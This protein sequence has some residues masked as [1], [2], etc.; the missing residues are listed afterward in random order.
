MRLFLTIDAQ[1]LNLDSPSFKKLKVGLK[2]KTIDHRWVP[3]EH[4]HIPV[5]SLGDVGRSLYL[6]LDQLIAG[7]VLKHHTFDLKLHGIWGFPEQAEA[8]VLWIG[9]QN[10]RELRSLEQDLVGTLKSEEHEISKPHLPIVRLRNYR[11]VTDVLSPF[12]N[13]DFGMLKVERLA[14]YEMTSGGAYPTYRLLNRYHFPL[15]ETH[16]VQV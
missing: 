5:L 9:V 10:S 16:F 1:E 7:I 15:L 2:K 6:A 3:Q 11:N 14:L 12:K 4:L 13:T 8:R